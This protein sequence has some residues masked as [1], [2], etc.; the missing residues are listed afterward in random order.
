MDASSERL[1]IVALLGVIGTVSAAII[2]FFGGR[3]ASIA[4]VQNALN[5]SFKDLVNGL[6]EE[7]KV[8]RLRMLQ[9]EAQCRGLA[10]HI[11]SLERIL[12][13][14]NIDVPRRPLTETV[15]VLDSMNKNEATN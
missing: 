1:V 11:E 14:H 3:G 8:D 15:F 9:I 5:A 6:Q 7:R 13:E 4:S 2:A 10:Q 12:R